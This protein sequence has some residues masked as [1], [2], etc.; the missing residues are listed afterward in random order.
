MAFS[1]I[2]RAPTRR[3]SPGW[4]GVRRRRRDPTQRGNLQRTPE[5]ICM[6]FNSTPQEEAQED[7][8][9]YE[10]GVYKAMRRVGYSSPTARYAAG[11]ENWRASAIMPPFNRR[12]RVR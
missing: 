11:Q 12:N 2:E 10:R 9:E 7:L 3:S 1:P 4:S 8:G 6:R 5:E